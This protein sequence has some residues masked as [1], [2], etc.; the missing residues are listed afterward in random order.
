MHIFR[1]PLIA[2]AG[3]FASPDPAKGWPVQE[4]LAIPASIADAVWRAGGI[5]AVLQPSTLA[6]DRPAATL[7]RFDGLLL[8]GGPDVDP[9]LYGE[10]ALPEVYGVRRDR[11]DFEIA[12]VRAALERSM[13]VLAVCR[14]IQLLNVALGGTLDQHI[15]GRAGL[16][17]HGIPGGGGHVMHDVRLHLGSR[18]AEAMGRTMVSVS[19]HHHQSLALLAESLEDS[20]WADDGMVEAVESRNGWVVAVQW[21]PEDTAAEDPAQQGLFDALVRVSGPRNKVRTLP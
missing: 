8:I 21:H 15:T 20:G 12:L 10:I 11:D 1:P 18:T 4:M 9:A 13:P 7:E 2:V 16:Q 5:P 14:G 6:T 3:G 17:A 19:S